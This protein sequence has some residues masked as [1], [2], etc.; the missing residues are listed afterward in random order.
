M[1]WWLFLRIL[2]CFRVAGH[3]EVIGSAVGLVP[4][5][6]LILIQFGGEFYWMVG[7]PEINAGTALAE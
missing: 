3:P 1:C 5:N 6:P 4:T 7:N 2:A